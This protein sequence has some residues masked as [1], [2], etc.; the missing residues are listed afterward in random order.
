[1]TDVRHFEKN[2]TEGLMTSFQLTHGLKIQKKKKKS[3]RSFL[4]SCV[5]SRIYLKLSI[6][7][8]IIL[9]LKS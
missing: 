6:L 8:F 1:M 2:V 5:D 9:F 4:F 3:S 7:F